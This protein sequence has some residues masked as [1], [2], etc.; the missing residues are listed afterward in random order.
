MSMK[1]SKGE[2]F[3]IMLSS[4][5][6]LDSDTSLFYQIDASSELTLEEVA[7]TLYGIS[8]A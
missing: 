7:N 1:L 5:R 8:F 4:E 3:G 2:T 6:N